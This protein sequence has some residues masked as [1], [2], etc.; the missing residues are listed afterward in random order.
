MT[1]AAVR[2]WLDWFE[3][4]YWFVPV[5]AGVIAVVLA[6]LMLWL[7]FVIPDEVL[8]KGVM[9]YSGSPSETRSSLVGIAGSIL[10]TAGI[11]FSLL[12]LPMSVAASQFGSRLLRVYLRDRTTQFI[13]GAFTGAFVYC[14]VAALSIPPTSVDANTPQLTM[15]FAILLTFISFFGLIALIHHMGVSL[16]APN[17]VAAASEELQS[18]VHSTWSPDTARKVIDQLIPSERGAEHLSKDGH[19]IRA[20]RLGYIQAVDPEII[21]PLAIK[22]DLVI[23]LVSK[24]GS[25]VQEG[26]VVALVYPPKSVTPLIA[27]NIRDCY[28]LGNLRTPAQDIEYAVNQLVEI[29]LRAMSAAINDPFT[30]MTCLDHLGAGLALYVTQR[31]TLADFSDYQSRIILTPITL[32]ELLDSAFNMLRRVSRESPDVLLAIINTLDVIGQACRKEDERAQIVRH[33]ELVKVEGNLSAAGVWDKER[34]NRRS[35]KLISIY[36]KP[37]PEQVAEEN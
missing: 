29:A 7:D 33:I 1:R 32:G 3:T 34:M 10:G 24:P 31:T 30:A 26:E 27:Q 12:T 8:A 6:R 19:P 23:H 22:Y 13:L 4:S 5:I 20:T 9:I 25:F 35:S 21:L 18:V 11:V 37:A 14:L 28:L 17:V 2:Q 15:T 36:S 16:E